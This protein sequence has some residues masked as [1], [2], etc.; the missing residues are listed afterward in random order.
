VDLSHL[1]V[2]EREKI[3]AVLA[4]ASSADATRTD[5]DVDRQVH[6]VRYAHVRELTTA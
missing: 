4:R 5:S 2:E 1:S 3:A 6:S